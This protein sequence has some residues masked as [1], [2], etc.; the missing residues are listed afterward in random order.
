MICINN[1]FVRGG[2]GHSDITHCFVNFCFKVVRS[3]VTI[4]VFL[5]QKWP[6]L[7]KRAELEWDSWNFIGQ[8]SLRPEFC[9]MME[10]YQELTWLMTPL[11]CGKHVQ[12]QYFS[13]VNFF[14]ARHWWALWTH[15]SVCA[16]ISLDL[17]V[18][19]SLGCAD[20]E[21]TPRPTRSAVV[22]WVCPGRERCPDTEHPGMMSTRWSAGRQH[23]STPY[24]TWLSFSG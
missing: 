7:D 23:P 16:R 19:L 13:R 4:E 21:W 9:L 15:S 3:A 11:T 18:C 12:M 14:L 5:S 8:K 1:T 10:L 24:V 6:H 20:L 22:Q 2:C 17:G